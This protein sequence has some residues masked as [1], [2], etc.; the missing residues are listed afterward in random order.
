MLAA[1]GL[2][3]RIQN[4]TVVIGYF[5]SPETLPAPTTQAEVSAPGPVREIPADVAMP[6]AAATESAISQEPVV[7]RRQKPSS[8]LKKQAAREASHA[9]PATEIPADAPQPEAVAATASASQPLMLTDAGLQAQDA[10]AATVPPAQEAAAASAP[11]AP[12]PA[13]ISAVPAWSGTKGQTLRDV[14]KKWSD[15]AGVEL[16]WAIDYDYR[17]PDDVG[18]P[19]AYD[20]AVGKLLDRFSTVRPQPYGQLHQSNEGPRVLVVKSY[21]LMP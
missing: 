11:P 13:A 16:Y 10:A 7:I 3:Y 18:Y 14:L 4:N 20:E 17:L 9:V 12:A 21:D 15:T 5:S 1:Q 8:L 2:G 19:G 6:S